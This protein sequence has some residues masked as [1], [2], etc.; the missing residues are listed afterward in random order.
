MYPL[1]W[2]DKEWFFTHQRN[3]QGTKIESGIF[4]STNL[5]RRTYYA[6]YWKSD[7]HICPHL[8]ENDLSLVKHV[9]I[10][11]ERMTDNFVNYFPNATELTLAYYSFRTAY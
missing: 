4:C 6:F 10:R 7:V 8:Q 3:R 5:Y 2:I 11:N 9:P 1:I